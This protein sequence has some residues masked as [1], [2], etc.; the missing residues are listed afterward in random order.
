M[1]LILHYMSK[2]GLPS[3]CYIFGGPLG[4][5]RA[6]S[7]VGCHPGSATLKRRAQAGEGLPYHAAETMAGGDHNQTVILEREVGSFGTKHS[8]NCVTAAGS[9]CPPHTTDGKYLQLC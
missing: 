5:D 1:L 9:K 8:R 3:Q 6:L 7:F 2:A 4:K